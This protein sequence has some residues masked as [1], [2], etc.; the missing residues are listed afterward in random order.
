MRKKCHNLKNVLFIKNCPKIKKHIFPITT[1]SIS[2]LLK[3]KPVKLKRV[4]S[5]VGK[6]E[7]S[8][9]L[10]CVFIFILRKKKL[11]I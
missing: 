1:T 9:I 11:K 8:M 10:L 3:Y 6:L 4:L 5:P 7:I 2:L